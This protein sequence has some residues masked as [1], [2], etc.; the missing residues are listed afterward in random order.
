MTSSS[1][2]DRDRFGIFEGRRTFADDIVFKGVFGATSFHDA[3][4]DGS[5]L[6]E[7]GVVLR[8]WK[9]W[10]GPEFGYDAFGTKGAELR[11]VFDGFPPEP[12][13]L[14]IWNLFNKDIYGL[15]Y[16][17]ERR[18]IVANVTDTY[19]LEFKIDPARS[20]FEWLFQPLETLL[21]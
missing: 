9:I 15:E 18:V 4:L 16:D 13:M 20:E 21:M 12:V 7:N 2:F 3:V 6:L 11:L 14:A 5:I 17:P 10:F 1:N 19:D 8:I